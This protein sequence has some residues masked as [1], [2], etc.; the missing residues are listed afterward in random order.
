M[1]GISKQEKEEEEERDLEC[2]LS[3]SLDFFWPPDI[4][5]LASY[6]V[7]LHQ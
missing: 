7:T 1:I 4:E 6:V 3:N 5:G 2:C